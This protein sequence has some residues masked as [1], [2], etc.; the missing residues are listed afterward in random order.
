LW[1]VIVFLPIRIR[2]L[3]RVLNI[4]DKPE[5]INLTFIHA[6][7]SLHCLIF[8][9]NLLPV[10]IIIFNILESTLPGILQNFGKCVAI[11]GKSMFSFAFG[12]SEYG[13]GRG[14][15]AGTAGPGIDPDP[16]PAK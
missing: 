11:S 2:V 16:D 8:I 3:P 13:S 7:A 4:L 6:C 15:S 1:L 10:G 5:E 14:S 12:A 9:V